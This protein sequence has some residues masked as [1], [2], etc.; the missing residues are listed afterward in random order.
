M[1]ATKDGY[2]VGI[3]L[4]NF[5]G[6]NSTTTETIEVSLP[7]G[8]ETSIVKTGKILVFVNLGYS[9]LDFGTAEVGLPDGSPT[10]NG[11]I[12][13]SL[14][15]A[16]R[17]TSLTNVWS[18]DQQTGKV[19]ASFTTGLDLKGNSLENVSK[20]LSANGSW[21]IDENG[22]LVV[23][24]VTTEELEVKTKVR[25]GTSENPQGITIYDKATGQPKCIFVE[26][27]VVN[28]A[29]GECN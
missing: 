29:Q 15:S 24:K 6:E 26:N 22:K 16:G 2:T 5:D 20:I 10:S 25:F 27:D 3:A 11:T 23:K 1:K 13:G 14:T 19:T 4:E 7:S 9:K 8:R 28:I 12:S 17:E 18:I 21:G